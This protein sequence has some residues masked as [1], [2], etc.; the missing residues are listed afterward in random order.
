MQINADFARPALVRFDR[1]GWIPSP[2]PGVERIPL[3]R[4][5]GEVARATSLVR[6]APGSQFPTHTHHGGEEFFVLEGTF[7]DETGDFPAGSYVRNPIGT[8][9]APH[10]AEGCVIWVKLWQFQPADTAQ[11]RLDATEGTGLLLPEDAD[12]LLRRDLHAFGTEEVF[13]QHLPAGHLLPLE[14]RLGGA[15]VLVLRGE[16]ALAGERLRRWSWTRQPPGA[17]ARL[18]AGGEGACLL[19]KQGHLGVDTLPLPQAAAAS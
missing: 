7:S 17:H 10:S 14:T 15:E 9:H 5:G 16:V 4:I 18:A 13:L 12:A 2:S 6:Y 11:V 8:A 3:D 19:I 1:A